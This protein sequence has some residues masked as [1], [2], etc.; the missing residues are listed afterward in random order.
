[1]RKPST[2]PVRAELVEALFFLSS[3]IEKGPPFDKLR[4]D[5]VIGKG[6]AK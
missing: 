6:A 4:A 2:H 1:M 5:G 3:N